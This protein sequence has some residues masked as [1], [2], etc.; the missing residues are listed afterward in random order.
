MDNVTNLF[1]KLLFPSFCNKCCLQTAPDYSSPCLKQTHC[2][3]CM[4]KGST[5]IKQKLCVFHMNIRSIYDG[6]GH[7]DYHTEHQKL[8]GILDYSLASY[9]YH[10]YLQ[11][12]ISLPDDTG[13]NFAIEM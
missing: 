10:H 7:I 5:T 12:I 13:L 4:T 9:K 3:Y 2:Q 6:S 1:H 11:F 8:T